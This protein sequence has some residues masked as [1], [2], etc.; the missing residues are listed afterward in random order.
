MNSGNSL[1][2]KST[3]LNSLIFDFHLLPFP[4]VKNIITLL[5]P[6]STEIIL[7]KNQHFLPTLY[8]SSSLNTRPAIKQ[9]IKNTIA[10]AMCIRKRINKLPELVLN[11]GKKVPSICAELNRTLPRHQYVSFSRGNII[12]LKITPA[13][14]I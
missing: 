9:H 1:L 10:R 3:L 5:F 7:F 4:E 14:A 11:K 13:R 8:S 6:N 2:K 12:R